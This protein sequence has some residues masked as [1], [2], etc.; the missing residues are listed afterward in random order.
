MVNSQTW[1]NHFYG[2]TD[3]QLTILS[4]MFYLDTV[5]LSIASFSQ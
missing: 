5:K 4:Y 1:F 3:W 2:F